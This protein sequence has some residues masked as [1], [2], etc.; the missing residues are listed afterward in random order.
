MKSKPMAVFSIAI[1]M[2]VTGRPGLAQPVASS[3]WTLS[4][5]LDNKQPYTGASFH[6][7]V[8]L[9]NMTSAPLRVTDQSTIGDY[10]VYVKDSNN[11]QVPYNAQTN[12]YIERYKNGPVFR[13][14]LIE[15]EP[16]G[17]T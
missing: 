7:T 4:A 16:G 13:S 8:T 1:G 2:A 5:E 11:T 12:G 14:T 3:S 15:V 10:E 9:K 6:L 17:T